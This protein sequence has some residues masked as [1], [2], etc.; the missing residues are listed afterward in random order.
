MTTTVRTRAPT[1][2]S[3]ETLCSPP[4]VSSPRPL[5][6][7]GNGERK[8]LRLVAAV[9]RRVQHHC[10]TITVVA[11]KIDVLRRHC[12]EIG[13]DFAIIEVTALANVLGA[14]DP[15][16]ILSEAAALA[17]LGV[18]AMSRLGWLRPGVG[19]GTDVGPPRG[20]PRRGGL[21]GFFDLPENCGTRG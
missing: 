13:R 16:A 1:T 3:L 11:H 17:D 2:S 12:D 21:T 20:A 6:I 5:L 18:D 9:R 19:P 4:P 14:G 10:S 7:G 8:T 15:E